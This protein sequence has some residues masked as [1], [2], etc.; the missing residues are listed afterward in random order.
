LLAPASIPYGLATD[1]TWVYW[2]DNDANTVSKVST[3]GATTVLLY[4]AGPYDVAGDSLL[5]PGV[6]VVDGQYVFFG[7]SS[8]D[9]YRLA[10]AGGL[11]VLLANTFNNSVYGTYFGITTDTATVYSGGNGIIVGANKLVADSGTTAASGVAAALGLA[12]D[13]TS[14]LIYWANFGS[15]NGNDGTVGRFGNDG[16][17]SQVL[18]ASLTTPEAVALG[19]SYVFWVSNGTLMA[20]SSETN[21]STGQLWRTA[22]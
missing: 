16:G 7:D 8:E 19:G 6:L 12:F 11:P 20:G 1:G 3:S 18:Q 15:G 22:K 5:E 13:P 10:T 9:V 17:A 14:G 21:P 4:D 2:V